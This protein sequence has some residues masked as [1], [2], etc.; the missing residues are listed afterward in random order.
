MAESYQIQ[1]TNGT[2]ND[3]VTVTPSD[4]TTYD[5]PL[6]ALWVG[7]GVFNVARAVRLTANGGN[8]TGGVVRVALVY[9]RITPPTS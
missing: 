1:R 5:P 2:A 9:I 6:A 8:F 7:T 3:A 4:S